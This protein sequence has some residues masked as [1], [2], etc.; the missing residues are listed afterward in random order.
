M[1]ARRANAWWLLPGA[2]ALVAV[3][4]LDLRGGQLSGAAVDAGTGLAWYVAGA[5][6]YMARPANRAAWLL[7]VMASLLAIGKGVGAGL[8]LAS[9]GHPE[10][11]HAWAAVVFVD[12]AGWGVLAAGVAVFVTFPDG[13]YQR[14]YERWVVRGLQLAFVPVQLL[15]LLGSPRV[16][17][18][19]FGWAA[20]DAI[21]PIYVRGLDPVGAIA[22]AVITANLLAVVPAL[23]L[24]L[25]RYRR[26]G[27][28]QRRQI[29]WPL[30][31]VSLS[32]ISF[33]VLAFG[34]GPPTI[35]FWVAATQYLITQALLPAGLAMGIVMHRALDIED[36]I[37]RSVVYGA[38]WAVIAAVYVMVAAAFGI[39][40]GQRVPLAL[41]VL[42]AIVATIFFQPARRRLERLADRLVFGPRLSGYELISQLGVRLQSTVAAE[43]VAGS[44]A[45]AVQAGLGA[46]WA[47]VTLNRPE[48]TAI[49][50]AGTA[51][52]VTAAVELSAPL[53][54]G[55]RV[56]G[57]IE[58]GPKVEGRYAAA[59]QELL[60]TLGR[61]AALAIRNSQLSAEL[62]GHLEELAASRARL[63]QAEEV[64][65]R[66]LERDLHDGVQQELV[67]VLARLG[68]ARN[69]L[70][71]DRDLAETTLREA[72]VDAQRA[73][74]GLQELARGI[75]PAILTDRGLIE[76]VEERATRMTVPVEV[77]ANGLGQ[78]ARFPLE[79]EGAA[80]FFVSEGL[81]NILKYASAS[82]VFV[83]F[84]F[85]PGQLVIEVADDGR[86]FD[87][88]GVKKSGLR[89]L[90]DRISA[91]G[92]RV[93]VASRPGHG[94]AL[95]AY[96]P[97]PETTHG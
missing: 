50:I 94:T 93:E 23:A 21:S 29:K 85:E 75:H 56:V 24:L 83:R 81:A 58:C 88:A 90:E 11:A 55:D 65:R 9:A 36:V 89:G 27:T 13:K 31:A 4:V 38:L 3:A 32:A 92:G 5:L 80:Y 44:V 34:P 62:S 79:L 66:R 97:V 76:A 37:R 35:P 86:G 10:V 41:A 17:T 33:A 91:L 74:E 61:Q 84:H 59:D 47:R 30:Y 39:A 51:P 69:Q 15:Q 12:A 82:R 95:R 67:G 77:H 43:D 26:F 49:A 68:L 1:T 52:A 45:T 2:F 78:G 57:V 71:R 6:A 72:Q 28:D 96:L 42:L 73:L 53:V 46:S 19:Q 48:P 87:P 54:Q 63:V 70:R 22:G 20:L 18:S 14:R 8:S 25:L 64:G 60:D 7:L 40:V 16:G